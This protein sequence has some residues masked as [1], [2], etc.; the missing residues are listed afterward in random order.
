MP[1]IHIYETFHARSDFSCFFQFCFTF[2][3]FYFF[4]PSG[5]AT[6]PGWN[7]YHETTTWSVV[8]DKL[9]NDA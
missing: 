4:K 1:G 7:K 5:V 6:E 2:S 9:S 3:L 8:S